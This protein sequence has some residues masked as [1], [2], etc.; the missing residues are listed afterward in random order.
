MIAFLS[1]GVDEQSKVLFVRLHVFALH[2][3]VEKIQS[4]PKVS[5]TQ[6]L[7]HLSEV[8]TRSEYGIQ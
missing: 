4:S 3:H 1:A 2:V 8:V 5:A 6:E 7:T